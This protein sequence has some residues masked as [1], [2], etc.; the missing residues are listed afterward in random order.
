MYLEAMLPALLGYQDVVMDRCWLSEAP[1]ADVFRCGRSRTSAVI[2]AMIERVAMRCGV[3][4]VLCLPPLETCLENYR[5]RRDKE[6]LDTEEQL[7]RVYDYYLCCTPSH[8]IYD[9]TA[10]PVFTTPSSYAF[11]P[12]PLGVASA[13]NLRA[14]VL[15]V[16]ENFAEHKN[17]DLLQQYPFVS[18][19]E[20]SCSMWL[21]RLLVTAGIHERDLLWA[22]SDQD[23][24]LIYNSASSPVIIALGRRASHELVNYGLEHQ[25]FAHPAYHRRFQNGAPY[26]LLE[27]LKGILHGK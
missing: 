2:M 9:Y 13:G 17:Q 6:M 5:A 12:H 15:I 3:H 10:T 27:I 1:Y 16:G 22:N 24:G 4:V 26:P 23:L 19:A 7:A 20:D 11:A 21:T 18:F 14:S 8:T 25:T